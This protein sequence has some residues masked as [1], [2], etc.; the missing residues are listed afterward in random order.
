MRF[1]LLLIFVFLISCSSMK[2]RK[3]ADFFQAP[4]RSERYFLGDLPV[5]ANYSEQGHCQRERRVRYLDLE[6]GQKSFNFSYR[7]ALALQGSYNHESWRKRRRSSGGVVSVEE[8]GKIFWEAADKV[9]EGVLSRRSSS[10]KALIVIIDNLSKSQILDIF[11]R[12]EFFENQVYIASYCLTRFSL[13]RLS[14]AYSLDDYGV[15][16]FGIESETVY[17]PDL[18]KGALHFPWVYLLPET[19]STIRFYTSKKSKNINLSLSF[20]GFKV[21]SF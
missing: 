9:Q 2:L 3:D 6:F 20:G 17:Q 18:I 15:E 5:W 13:E 21:Q 19:I 10:K 11:Q 7:E 16:V 12:P 14:E 8:E 1:S 4:T